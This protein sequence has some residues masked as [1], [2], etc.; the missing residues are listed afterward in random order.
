[1]IL[2]TP[3]PDYVCDGKLVQ[4]H[5]DSLLFALPIQSIYLLYRYTINK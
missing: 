5:G 3:F 2:G 1:M 4:V